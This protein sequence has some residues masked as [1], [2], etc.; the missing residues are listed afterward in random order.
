ML[1]HHQIETLQKEEKRNR[2]LVYFVSDF[3][4]NQL[5]DLEIAVIQVLS[6]FEEMQTFIQTT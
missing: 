1:A 5:P 4:F 2:C 6:V 3:L